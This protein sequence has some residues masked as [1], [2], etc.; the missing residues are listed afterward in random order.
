MTGYIKT[1]AEPPTDRREVLR[2]AG[3][4]GE[5]PEVET[6]LESC[7]SELSGKMTYSVC[8][9]AFPV[10]VSEG[11]TCL[12]FAQCASRSLE[13]YLRGCEEIVLFGATVGM[14]VDR[15][16]AKYSRVA[17]SKALLF[18][19]IGT[20]RIESLCDAFCRDIACEWQT[21]GFRT[22]SRFSPGYGDV[23][24]TLQKNIFEALSGLSKIGL[25]LNGSMLMSPSKSVTALIGLSKENGDDFHTGCRTCQKENCEYR[26][27]P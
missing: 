14:E 10:S 26:R 11:I 27:I 22:R 19:A 12:G 21:R 24:L 5:A 2:Y 6:L 25:T 1:Y 18:Q 8:Y 16:I 13:Q 17:P 4:R 20:E 23:P 15:L 9:A 3:V 7:L